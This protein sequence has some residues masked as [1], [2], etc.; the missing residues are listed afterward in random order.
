MP[1]V[2]RGQTH[3]KK[4]KTLHAKTKGYMWG[5]RNL[6]KA[7][8]EAVVK[9]GAHSYVDRRKKKRDFRGLWQIRI[10][11]FAREYGLSYSSFIGKLKKQSIEIDR[12]VLAD[13]A[14]NN[15]KVLA[16]IAGVE[17]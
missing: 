14:I 4:R 6:I 5:R 2:K 9:A 3:T 15:K 10:G 7:A 12:K 13:L 8:K 11:A 1:R 16:K 17:K